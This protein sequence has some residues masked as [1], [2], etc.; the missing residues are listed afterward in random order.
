MTAPSMLGRP[1][2]A[3]RAMPSV[4]AGLALAGAAFFAGFFL[5]DPRGLRVLIAAALIVVFIGLGFLAPHR[6]LYALVVW[7]TVLGFLRR[8]VSE[9]GAASSSA[10]VLLLVGPAAIVVLFLLAARRDAFRNRTTL[11]NAVLAL[12]VLVLLGAVNPL[13]GSLVAGLAGLLFIL[14]PTLG[15]WIGRVL[16]DDTTLKRV[17]VTVALFSLAEAA[18][19]LAQTFDGFPSWDSAWIATHQEQYAALYV[20]DFIRPFGSFSSFAEYSYFLGIGLIV[21]AAVAASRRLLLFAA[22]AALLLVVAI[23]FASTRTT[24]VALVAALGLVTAALRR[25]PLSA[26]VVLTAALLLLVPLVASHFNYAGANGGAS[27]S[28]ASHQVGGLANPLD[29]QQSTLRD[30][31][32]LMKLGLV[33]AAHNPLGNGIGGVTIAG[34]RFGG[35]EQGTESDPSNVA[36]ALGAPGLLVY[37]VLVIAG[38]WGAYRLAVNRRDALAYVALAL[39]SLTFLQW[40]NGGQYSIAF[41]VWVTLGWIDR[42]VRQAQMLETP[43]AA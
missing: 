37:V 32:T 20:G 30:H 4:L 43:S 42:E 2:A 15:F 17:L 24:I 31:L 26:A 33:G 38:F 12:S 10:D 35:V 41:L 19:G 7:L 40:L 23:F 22:P 28:L 14:I 18:Y 16:C 27:E 36:V 8:F 25:F 29:P 3:S 1:A 39:I 6:L 21:W 11:A 34:A 9:Y 13:Q 5:T